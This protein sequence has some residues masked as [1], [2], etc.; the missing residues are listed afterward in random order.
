[1]V[2]ACNGTDC[3]LPA[4]K[5]ESPTHLKQYVQLFF[6]S[7]IPWKLKEHW[8]Q[9]L[10][11]WELGNPE[12]KHCTHP[13]APRPKQQHV[14]RFSAGP[15][16]GTVLPTCRHTMVGL[17]EGCLV[18]GFPLKMVNSPSVSWLKR[19]DGPWDKQPAQ[20]LKWKKTTDEQEWS[21]DDQLWA[22]CNS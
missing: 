19:E 11:L 13:K 12:W 5:P 15:A 1:M 18:E 2:Q 3:D 6:T 16:W 10:I 14:C 22:L 9:L 20:N 7:G 4:H 8:K 21:H 17:P